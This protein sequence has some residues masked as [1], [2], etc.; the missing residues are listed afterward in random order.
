MGVFATRTPHR[1]CPLGL[2][3]AKVEGVCGRMLLISGADLVD[4]TP[5]LDVK[6]YLPFCDTVPDATAPQWVKAGDEDDT[7]A[8]AAVEFSSSFKEELSKCWEVMAKFSMYSSPREFQE[9]LE[10][11]LSRDIRSLRQRKN[12]QLSTPI[13]SVNDEALEEHDLVSN[14]DGL[15]EDNRSDSETKRATL[16]HDIEEV[17][18]DSDSNDKV[19]VY[20]LIL[21]GFVIS[22]TVDCG[23]VVVF[24]VEILRSKCGAVRECNHSTWK[25][26]AGSTTC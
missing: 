9:L 7:I 20:K 25:K 11:V 19:V 5:V 16:K 18:K 22:Y 3:V 1:P 4:G 8:L 26:V 15:I 21:E 10:Q 6:P 13:S 2:T 14:E 23:H 12:P 17:E 24:G